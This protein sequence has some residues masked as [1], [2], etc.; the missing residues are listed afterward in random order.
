MWSRIMDVIVKTLLSVEPA[1][2]TATKEACIHE[3]SCFELYG[4]DV[5]VD[6]Q[7]KPWLLEVNLSPS[8]QADSPLDKQIKSSLLADAF[9]LLGVRRL[10]PQT[11]TSAR[12]RA[13]FLYMSKLQQ[14]IPVKSRNLLGHRQDP[15]RAQDTAEDESDAPVSIPPIPSD[16]GE[17]SSPSP[18]SAATAAPAA[19][20]LPPP[21][22]APSRPFSPRKQVCL[23]T[24]NEPHL[25]LLVHALEENQRCSNFIR[26]YPTPDTVRRYEP[27]TRSRHSEDELRSRLLMAVLFGEQLPLC[28]SEPA[29]AQEA[30]EPP[31]AVKPEAEAPLEPPETPKVKKMMLPAP[32][33]NLKLV[34]E[35][36]QTLKVLGSKMSSQ[37]LLMEYLVRL[38]N[39][40]HKLSD[41][42]RRKLESREQSAIAGVLQVFRQQLS[43]YL[44]A[45]RRRITL[46]EKGSVV[47]EVEDVCTQALAQ[48][49]SNTWGAPREA[50]AR[51][52]EGSRGDLALVRCAP[53]PFAQSSS[54]CR[55]IAALG[56]LTATDLESIFRAPQCQPELKSLFL[57]PD[58]AGDVSWNVLR[59]MSQAGPLS[60]LEFLQRVTANLQPPRVVPKSPEAAPPV[61]PRLVLSHSSP[62][63]KRRPGPLAPLGAPLG[64]QGLAYSRK[65]KLAFGSYPAL[66]AD[67]EL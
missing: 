58:T 46:E 16:E 29:P 26:L 19:P 15:L 62:Q 61:A 38:L 13:R 54:G 24:V 44:R 66:S 41:S 67:I 35:A 65:G 43:L 2:S 21:P 7:L 56:E 64:C 34:E 32:A 45:G 23:N 52:I 14:S 9:N 33:S 39:T 55:A 6:E 17:N 11:L 47:E 40:C 1:I 3:Q 50:A 60:E 42:A 57:I 30:P 27:I 22:P 49:L 53:E 36:L 8:M 5:L 20:P 48:I 37:L 10:D 63:L 51:A 18:P 12:L 31:Q 28:E 25:R 59:R 4:F